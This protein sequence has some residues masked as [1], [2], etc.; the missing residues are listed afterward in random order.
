MSCSRYGTFTVQ[1][2]VVLINAFIKG[3]CPL[4]TFYLS[5][6]SIYLSPHPSILLS[7]FISSQLG[8]SQTDCCLSCSTI[9][10]S[11][12]LDFPPYQIQNLYG[13]LSTKT[14]AMSATHYGNVSVYNAHNL[15]G[16]TEQIATNRALSDIRQKRPFLLTRSSFLSTGRHSA[17]WT[18]DNGK[19]LSVCICL[20]MCVCVCVCENVCVL[21]TVTE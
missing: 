1:Y 21:I 16:L 10:P 18:G 8:A 20:C 7:I 3:I 9:D 13:R 14:I 17:K 12:P 5:I 19:D 2:S 11:N 15:Y 6:R 4:T